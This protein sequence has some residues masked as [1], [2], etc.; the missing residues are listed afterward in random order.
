MDFNIKFDKRQIEKLAQ[1]DGQLG[2]TLAVGVLRVLLKASDNVRAQIKPGGALT[3]HSGHLGKSW[4][5]GPG[6]E[7][8]KTLKH[9]R[10]NA[11]GRLTSK[12][13]GAAIQEFGGVVRAV[14]AKYLAIPAEG[15]KTATGTVRDLAARKRTGGSIRLVKEVTIPASHYVTNA[16][17]ETA[18]DAGPI[19]TAVIQKA[20]DKRVAE[21]RA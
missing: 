8:Q 12:H 2:R 9:T 5:V 15:S 10:N 18:K 7:G 13:P 6:G 17:E 16:T 11:W 19:M 21:G 3:P 4:N 1:L 14:R 20:L